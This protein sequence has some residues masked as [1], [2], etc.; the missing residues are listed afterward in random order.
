M[1]FPWDCVSFAKAPNRWGGES[2]EQDQSGDGVPVGFLGQQC[3]DQAAQRDG[4][5]DGRRCPDTAHLTVR[6]HHVLV[7]RGEERLPETAD[8][9]LGTT[10]RLRAIQR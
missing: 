1:S 9:A 4:G 8:A 7:S 2:Q 3:P 6:T 10:E 5:D